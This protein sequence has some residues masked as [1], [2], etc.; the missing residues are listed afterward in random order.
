MPSPKSGESKKDYISRFMKSGEAQSDFPDE[1]QRL[2]VAYSMF[3]KRNA[4]SLYGK[5]HPWPKK[6]TCSFI[7][8]GLVHYQD[9]GPC[10]KCGNAMSCSNGSEG[11]G[12]GCEPTGEHVLVKQEAL[13][14]MAQSF[15]GKPVID[16]MHKDV[17]PDT[18]AE[19]EADGI[20][21]RVWL[22]DKTGWWMCEFLVW[23]PE[24]QLHCESSAYSVSCA[25]EPTAVNQD[26]GEYHNI[27]YAEE[28]EDGSYTHLAIVT[29]PRYEGARIFVNS[30]GGSMSWRKWLPGARKNA[31]PLDPLKTLVD[32]DGEKVPL[33]NLHDALKSEEEK[34]NAEAK[35]AEEQVLNDD[36]MVCEIDGKEHKLGELKQAYRASKKNADAPADKS[37]PT[38][39]NSAGSGDGEPEKL[40]DLRRQNAD[41]EAKAAEE[42]KNADDAAKAAEE[43]KNADEKA[44]EEKKNAD[45]AAK[46][47]ELKKNADEEAKAAEEKKNA[48][49]KA[50]AEA[51]EKKKN[52]EEKALEE[53][54]NAGRK[55]F[56]ALRNAREGFAGEPSKI[57]PASIDERLAKGKAKYG[58]AV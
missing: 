38:C 19:G 26:G 54:R 40:P 34:K 37:C 47:E 48:D 36:E 28:I 4:I 56:A 22:D 33:Q 1:K 51:L 52:A 17:T 24:A 58:S 46:A 21:T 7:E 20:V 49:D 39:G 41:A 42:K 5:E 6:Y 3:E 13:A 44:L 14:K 32:V 45:D 10:K 12:S 29:N 30:K 9:L 16:K 57:L 55:S 2:A 11:P 23:N 18:V 27:P 25:Y 43:K 31:A 15:V 50:A 8:P 53:K 35:A